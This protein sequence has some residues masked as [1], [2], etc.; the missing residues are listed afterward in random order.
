MVLISETWFCKCQYRQPL[1]IADYIFV[2][3][4]SRDCNIPLIKFLQLNHWLKQLL[5]VAL[6]C[7]RLISDY[8][9]RRRIV[10]QRILPARSST[11]FSKL[12]AFGTRALECGTEVEGVWIAKPS[13]LDLP[14]ATLKRDLLSCRDPPNQICKLSAVEDDDWPLRPSNR[15]IVPLPLEHELQF[16]FLNNMPRHHVAERG[17]FMRRQTDNI[18]HGWI[19]DAILT[20]SRVPTL[21][22]NIGNRKR[23]Y[24]FV[25]ISSY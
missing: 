4:R 9:T 24:K 7:I 19:N 23:T 20:D 10:N 2:A 5:V 22:P 16:E 6:G 3:S 8:W 11:A 17:Q 25:L 21:E 15:L 13:L 1:P 14:Y 12:D 18:G